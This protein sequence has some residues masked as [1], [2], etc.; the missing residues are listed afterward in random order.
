MVRKLHAVPSVS[1]CSWNV[2]DP[3]ESPVTSRVDPLV[4]SVL[5]PVAPTGQL[6]LEDL[7]AA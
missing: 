7:R 6:G 2:C 3:A 5:P 1:Y 4:V